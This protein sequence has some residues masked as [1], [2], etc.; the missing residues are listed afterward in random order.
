[1]KLNVLLAVAALAAFSTGCSSLARGGAAGAVSPSADED[2]D[3]YGPISLTPAAAPAGT[4][5][6]MEVAWEDNGVPIRQLTGTGGPQE[7]KVPSSHPKKP[8]SKLPA[9]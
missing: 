9:K 8:L 6:Q 5:G 3:D 7:M 4:P 2:E 1:M